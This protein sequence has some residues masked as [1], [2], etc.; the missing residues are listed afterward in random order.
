MYVKK[1]P[2]TSI[3]RGKNG[4]T[5]ILTPGNKPVINNPHQY[6]DPF[7]RTPNTKSGEI[8]WGKSH[9]Q[10][11]EVIKHYNPITKTSVPFGNISKPIPKFGNYS[12]YSISHQPWSSFKPTLDQEKNHWLARVSYDMYNKKMQKLNE[13]ADRDAYQFTRGFGPLGT[14][15]DGVNW[16]SDKI[17]AQITINQHGVYDETKWMGWYKRNDPR[18]PPPDDWHWSKYRNV[19]KQ[20]LGKYDL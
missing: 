5:I 2:Q 13:I 3:I 12:N 18:E 6:N 15:F 9:P 7:H 1:S 19:F 17:A 8:Q 4:K 11:L 14:L 10:P 20:D 16:A